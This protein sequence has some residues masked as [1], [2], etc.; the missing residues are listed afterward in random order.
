MWKR[1]NPG[2][3]IQVALGFTVKHQV[4]HLKGNGV[5]LPPMKPKRIHL[6]GVAGTGMGAM[7]G[8]LKSKGLDV[9]GSD[10]SFYP[11]IGPFLKRIGVRL[12]EGYSAQHLDPRPD[13]VIIGN[14]VRKDNPEALEVL[15]QGIPYLSFPDALREFW[16]KDRE[17]ITICGTHGKTTTSALC[18]SAL[19]EKRPGFFVGGIL[20]G[21]GRGF[22]EGC[23]PWFVIEGD[24]YD[25]AFFDKT[26]K[27][28]HYNP[29]YVLLTSIEFDHADIY[30][31]LD[32]V[33]DAFLRLMEI[34]PDDGLL[35]ACVDS[36]VV[37][38]VIGACGAKVVT[39]GSREEADYRLG[40]VQ[41]N[42][43]RT[44]F[45]IRKK[46][47]CTIEASI[48]LPGKHNA[49][50]ATGVFALLCEIGIDHFEIL[51]G[52]KEARGVKRR[53]EIVAEGH[54]ITLIDDFAHHPTA[55]HET[56]LALRQ[57]YRD[58]RRIIACFE[59]R[60][61]TSRRGTFQSAYPSALSVA[62]MVM[63]REVPE[64]EKAPKGDRFSSGRLVGDLNALGVEAF[65]FRDGHEIYD[66]LRRRLQDGDLVV[67]LSNGAFEGLVQRLRE[68]I[69]R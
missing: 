15:R 52:L 5:H 10:T 23:P 54:G 63:V 22:S 48:L 40:Q 69:T 9:Q 43:D 38:E 21:L 68:F 27:F 34:I 4:A 61:N 30:P 56:L 36:P 49:L 51:E 65:L 33:K 62:D 58:K 31:D 45:S 37:R 59:P 18:V 44:H 32:H 7:A 2:A 29:K 46:C 1:F 25:T 8:L 14:V 50:N 53:Q 11:P 57:R 24:E 55:V 47:S 6:I 39:Y 67:V 35:V 28:L 13:L 26:P 41:V 19:R 64:P 20:K 16:L 42:R 60:T 17:V 12:F 66:A 3:I